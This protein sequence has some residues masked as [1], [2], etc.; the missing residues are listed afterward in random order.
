MDGVGKSRIMKQ[1]VTDGQIAIE[2]PD[3]MLLYGIWTRCF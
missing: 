2:F 1:L 3:G